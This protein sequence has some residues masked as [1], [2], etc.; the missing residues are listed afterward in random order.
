MDSRHK[1]TLLSNKYGFL[2]KV[3]F[4]VILEVVACVKEIFS[5]FN[6]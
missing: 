2:F 6:A 3:I 4:L 1:I 5:D